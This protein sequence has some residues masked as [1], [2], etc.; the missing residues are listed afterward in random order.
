[1]TG[2]DSSLGLFRVMGVWF[3]CLRVSRVSCGRC[4]SFGNE[5]MASWVVLYPLDEGMVL[6]PPRPS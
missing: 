2:D 4:D 1:M 3:H 5:A 6:P